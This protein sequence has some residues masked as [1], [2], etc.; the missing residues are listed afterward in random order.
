MP[1]AVPLCMVDSV[2]FNCF[3]V[4]S[5]FDSSASFVLALT[6]I[7]RPGSMIGATPSISFGTLA[8]SI[9]LGRCVKTLPFFTSTHKKLPR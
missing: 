5:S 8:I 4:F 3:A 1:S 6:S 9:C 7:R 2:F